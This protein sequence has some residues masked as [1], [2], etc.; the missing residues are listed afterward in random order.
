MFVRPVGRPRVRLSVC[1]SPLSLRFVSG[2]NGTGD[3]WRGKLPHCPKSPWLRL[4]ESRSDRA[5]TD[6]TFCN[7][8]RA[9]PG[10]SERENERKK[11][12]SCVPTR[13]RLSCSRPFFYPLLQGLQMC[14]GITQKWRQPHWTGTIGSELG[15]CLLA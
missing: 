11:W 8:G 10:E 12:P 13:R 4:C 6:L 14:N 5:I 9:K 7:V 3:R 1:A 2:N 15:K